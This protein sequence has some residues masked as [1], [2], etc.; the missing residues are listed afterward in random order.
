MLLTKQHLSVFSLHSKTLKIFV[1]EDILAKTTVKPG[2]PYYGEGGRM[3]ST[4]GKPSGG[5][6]GNNPSSNHGSS[7]GGRK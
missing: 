5:N 1:K 3:P 6:R 7:K 2:N 4:T